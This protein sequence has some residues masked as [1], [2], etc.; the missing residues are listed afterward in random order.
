MELLFFCNLRSSFLRLS[1]ERKKGPKSLKLYE[2]VFQLF[3]YE[4][5]H[6]NWQ[7]QK[8]DVAV[9]IANTMKLLRRDENSI[10][11]AFNP[12][13]GSC[14]DCKET[15]LIKA[16]YIHEMNSVKLKEEYVCMTEIV[17]KLCE[18]YSS[19]CCSNSMRL[20]NSPVKS[21]VILFSHPVDI[22]I[23]PSKNLWGKR[24]KYLSHISEVS[25]DEHVK[26]CTF[27][28]Q[29]ESM[30]YQNN[31]G[32]ICQFPFGIHRNVKI[33]SMIFGTMRSKFLK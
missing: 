22:N 15:V 2:F 7:L 4:K 13:S 3:R 17:V 30:F 11:S 24:L 6:W 5:L 25:Y 29:G 26:Y 31:I 19:Q 32:E 27:F 16:K 10:S 14:Q 28:Q 8:H 18:P 9:F 21:L 33:L 12:L 1:A 23:F 20:L